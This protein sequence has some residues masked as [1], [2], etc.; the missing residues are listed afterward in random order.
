MVAQVCQYYNYSA[1]RLT[2]I[3]PVVPQKERVNAIEGMLH[4]SL[5]LVLT[6]RLCVVILKPVNKDEATGEA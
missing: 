4:K 2:R 6:L 5:A 3:A 1:H